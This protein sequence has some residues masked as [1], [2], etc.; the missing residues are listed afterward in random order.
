MSTDALV[1][2]DPSIAKPPTRRPAV[3]TDLAGDAVA[4]LCALTAM[5]ALPA[6]AQVQRSFVN[7]GFEQPD[8]ATAG[9]RACISHDQVPGGHATHRS[10]ATQSS[11][12]CAVPS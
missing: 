5:V 12:G 6:S 1:I 9:C 8:P 3:R 2:G 4:S 11:G 10:Q 7:P